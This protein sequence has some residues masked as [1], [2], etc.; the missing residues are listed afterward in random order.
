MYYLHF[1]SGDIVPFEGTREQKKEIYEV[2]YRHLGLVPDH[3]RYTIHLIPHENNPSILHVYVDDIVQKD[4]MD[5][6]DTF[7]RWVS[8]EQRRRTVWINPPSSTETLGEEKECPWNTHYTEY[9]QIDVA[10]VNGKMTMYTIR[11]WKQ[12]DGI[13]LYH[14]TDLALARYEYLRD[15]RA[16]E[17]DGKKDETHTE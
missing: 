13:E 14:P 7:P 10:E 6:I 15:V 12:F 2:V 5:N 8:P 9:F 3:V 1:L 4:F 11:Y 16:L 17:K